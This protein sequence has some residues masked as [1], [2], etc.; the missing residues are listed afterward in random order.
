VRKGLQGILLLAILT[1][2]L[3]AVFIGLHAEKV[4]WRKSVKRALISKATKNEFVLLKFTEEEKNELLSWEHEKEFEFRGSMYDVISEEVS[5]DTTYYYCWPDHEETR[6]NRKLKELLAMTS[7]NKPFDDSKASVV[8]QF[9][10]SLVKAEQDHYVFFSFVEQRMINSL[11]EERV[12][13]E[14]FLHINSPPPDD[15]VTIG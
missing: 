15:E 6:L 10:K 7:G 14:S 1:L 3:A 2:P 13:N 8:L 12:N 9:L 4:Q 5:G 11:F